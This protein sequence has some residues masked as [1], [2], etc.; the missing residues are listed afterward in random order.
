MVGES[1]QCIANKH[2][3]NWLKTISGPKKLHELPKS[4]NRWFAVN[5]SF[6]ARWHL[7]HSW[8]V[9]N[10]R[11]A[12]RCSLCLQT[13]RGFGGTEDLQGPAYPTCTHQKNF[14]RLKISLENEPQFCLQR[15]CKVKVTLYLFELMLLKNC[16]NLR[17]VRAR[18]ALQK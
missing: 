3:L 7:Q 17:V 5:V 10:S 13:K 4:K 1:K 11:F 8:I 18:Q 2:N 6:V 9:L 14:G 16:V 12:C 15:S